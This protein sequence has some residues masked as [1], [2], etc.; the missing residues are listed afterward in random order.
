MRFIDHAWQ[1][2]HR[3]WSIRLSLFVGVLTGVASV[4]AAFVDVVNPWVLLS[5][6]VVT[7][8]LLIPLSRL[9]KQS[10]PAE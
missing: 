8:V 3:L 1:E 5:V 9:I 6:S 2:F 10:D 4:L 7:N